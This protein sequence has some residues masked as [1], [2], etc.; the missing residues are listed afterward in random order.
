MSEAHPTGAEVAALRAELH[1]AQAA[2]TGYR[3]MLAQAHA[4]LLYA[5]PFVKNA[6]ND[7]N[8][9]V[10]HWAIKTAELIQA[11]L[12]DCLAPAPPPAEAEGWEEVG[13]GGG[14][15][16]ELYRGARHD[17]VITDVRIAPGGK[18]LLIK[19]ARVALAAAGSGVRD[20]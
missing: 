11:A 15:L 2:I 4:A 19:T 5:K 6:G 10:R 8:P 1:R 20:G 18:S 13:E 16:W 14:K 17:H 7:E 9:E 12:A 3:E